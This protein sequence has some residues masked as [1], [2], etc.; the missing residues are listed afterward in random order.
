MSSPAVW[1]IR[2]GLVAS[3]LFCDAAAAVYIA[4]NS[5]RA[6]NYT[7]PMTRPGELARAWQNARLVDLAETYLSIRMEFECFQDYWGP[8]GPG[9][10]YV[11][12]L[13]AV[14]RTS[15]HDAVRSAYLGGE[16]D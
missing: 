4:V 15:L 1:D 2:G 11:S 5:R 16:A 10:E 14:Q 8:Y 6:L 9:A 7:R 13:T 12:T 3:R